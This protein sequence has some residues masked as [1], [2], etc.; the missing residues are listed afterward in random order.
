M[1]LQLDHFFKLEESMEIGGM[2]MHPV[3]QK[4][5]YSNNNLKWRFKNEKQVND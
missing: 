2:D 4:H 1:K 5:N 3:N